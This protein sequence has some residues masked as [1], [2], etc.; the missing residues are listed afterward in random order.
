M[1]GIKLRDYQQKAIDDTVAALKR[2]KRKSII[3][4]MPTGGGK[5]VVF[6][7]I[8]SNALKKKSNVLILTDRDELLRGTGSTLEKFGIMPKYITAGRKYPPPVEPNGNV[9]VGMAQ[10]L[11]KRLKK[12]NWLKW[13][14]TL[15]L[16]IIDEIH[17][18]EFNDFFE[19][20][21]FKGKTIIAVSATPK[22]GGKQRQ[23]KTDFDEIVHTKT[24]NELIDMGFL[25][26]D[27]YYGFK[28]SP[29]MK[30]V[31][32]NSKGDCSESAMFRRFDTPKVYG[33]LINM[34]KEHVNNTVMLVFCSNIIHCVRT[35][36]QLNEN[37]IPAK[38]LCSKLS[39]PKLPDSAE[40][41][42]K[43]DA[44]P[45]WVKYWEKLEHYNEY[46]YYF[47][48]YSGQ[49]GDLIRRWKE[50]E[51][52]VMVNPGILTTGFDYPAIETVALMRATISEVLY[53]QMLGRGSRPSKE[54][55]KTHFNILDFGGNAPRLGGYKMPRLWN[56]YHESNSG[57]GVPPSKMCGEPGPDKNGKHGCGDY[58]LASSKICP[59]CGYV[60]PEKKEEKEVDLNLMFTDEKGNLKAA[61]PVH[62][63]TFKEI[64][65]FSEAC[66]YKQNWKVIQLYLR[67]GMDELIEYARF[68]GYAVGWATRMETF[69]PRNV[70]EAVNNIK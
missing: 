22:R 40:P 62:E 55:G 61:K 6:S 53:L 2:S 54:T 21:I 52:K 7:Y 50:G 32:K 28:E 56:L 64:D 60:Y 19:L 69:I 34:Y 37:G 20:E 39:K 9:F 13:F 44:P 27:M 47:L 16:I 57:N 25:M 29:D 17:G 63:M 23:L 4:E 14:G 51:F 35:T 24:V 38:F 48:E 33:G 12:E 65:M 31:A 1:S 70:K 26:P 18:Q 10:T 66:K 49:R 59:S 30:G 15:D 5:T 3:I 11:R 8:A 46:N 42:S 43:K 68:K 58:I 45:E 41:D 67:G 36:K